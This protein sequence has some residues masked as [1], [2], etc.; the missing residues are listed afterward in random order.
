VPGGRMKPDGKW[1][2]WTCFGI[3]NHGF[4]SL[5]PFFIDWMES[6]HPAVAAPLGGKLAEFEVRTPD[7][8]RLR[9]I[10]AALD[11]DIKVTNAPKAS[12]IATLE[13]GK[14]GVELSS[15]SPVPRGYVI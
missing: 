7:G 3:R 15:F 12:V 14:G 10:F 9:E 13:S 4:G 1:L 8:D 6:E 2:G 5:V 11:L